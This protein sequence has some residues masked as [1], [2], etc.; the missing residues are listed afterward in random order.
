[1]AEHRPEPKQLLPVAGR[2]LVEYTLAALPRDIAELVF[3][4]GGPY[5][6]RIRE[7]FGQEHGGRKVT[8]VQQQEPLGLGH[9]IQQAA[10]AVHDRFLTFV[11]DD[12]FAADDLHALV[13]AGDLTV[14]ASRVEHPEN[15]GVLVCD[16]AGCLVRAV[17]KPKT[18]VSDLVSTGACL[19][20][21]GFFRMTVPPSARG[22]VELLDLVLALA[23]D[24]G[25]RVKVLEASF[26]LPVNDPE[27]LTEAERAM[28]QRVAS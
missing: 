19:L 10:P 22:E 9:A 17:E 13:R 3:V 4:V 26:W 18:F 1:M 27:Q 14:L 15:F 23:R 12:I 25:S 28:L 21:P 7:Y 6:A 16:A 2:P 11:P 24:Q 8:Y 5:E 20:D